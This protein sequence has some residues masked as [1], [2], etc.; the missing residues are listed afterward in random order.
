M[1]LRVLVGVTGG[2]AA[3]KSLP[4]I[5][6]LKRLGHEVRVIATESAF[7]FVGR[8][9][10]AAL[11]ENPVETDLYA[12]TDQVKHIVLARWGELLVVAPA[13]AA[14]LSRLV[15]GSAWDLLD[16]VALAA[17]CP[18]LV[19]PAMHSEM[20]QNA[21]TVANVTLLRERGVRVLEP[22][23]GWLSSGDF[24]SGRLPE[25]ESIAAAALRLVVPQDLSSVSALVT[26]GGTREPIDPV[27]YI[28]NRSS[29]R[30][31]VAIARELWRRG[32]S[33]KLIGCNLS[34]P[35]EFGC[36]VIPV[37][38]VSELAQELQ[39]AHADVL[40]M[41]AAVSD[42]T[43]QSSSKKLNRSSETQSLILKPTDD[44]LADFT[45]R[46]PE[47]LS[48][49]FTLQ[50]SALLRDSARLKLAKKSVDLMVAN[51][52]AALEG[53]STRGVLL[54]ADSEREFECSKSELAVLV[55]DEIVKR[56]HVLGKA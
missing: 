45:S 28:G 8:D 1:P 2:I 5:R 22:D 17:S 32:A 3:Y 53:Q 9:S 12:D 19:A 33:V 41:A 36:Q 55:V 38:T 37:S 7:H 42:F 20:W 30:T 10:L 47:T 46:N 34:A 6:E 54:A 23:A 44:L 40:V 21:A 31:G 48:V 15:A 26:A 18:I 25:P 13:T 51:E 43:V 14:F 4:L 49:G 56:L 11:S 24:G 50:E 29:G 39:S 52:L 27:R 35:V 16:N